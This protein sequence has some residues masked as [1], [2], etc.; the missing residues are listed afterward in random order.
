MTIAHPVC[1]EYCTA[2]VYSGC[3]VEW[4]EPRPGGMI[5]CVVYRGQAQEV[6]VMLRLKRVRKRLW[7]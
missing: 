4:V 6:H 5:G 1:I 7:T 3:S 2:P